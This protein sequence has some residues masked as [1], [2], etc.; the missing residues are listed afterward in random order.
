MIKKL[1]LIFTTVLTINLNSQ[2]VSTF[3]FNVN[4]IAPVGLTTALDAASQRW[5]KYISI[6]I[7]IK[8]NLFFVNSSFL[9]FSAITLSNGRTNFV[10]AP[11]TN[12]IY[13]TALANQLAGLELNPGEYDMDIYVNLATNYYFGTGKPT[14][15]QSDFISTIMHEIGHGLGFYSSG[16]V[17]STNIGSFGNVPAS[18]LAP[19]TTSF[20]W[21]GQDG[22]PSIYDKY[23][24]KQSQ[25]NL[26][27]LAPNNTSTLGDSIKFRTNY[28][29]GPVYANASNGGNPIKLSG[30]TGAFTLGVDL[31]HIH[32]TI[33]G[34]IMSYCWGDGDTV[35]KPAA[36]E[37]GILREIGWNPSTV[38]ITENYTE[39]HFNLYPNPAQ[40]FVDISGENIQSI[41]VYS[42]Q[43]QLLKSEK[44]VNNL[45]YIK[46]SVIELNTGIYFIRINNGNSSYNFSRKLVINKI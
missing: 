11:I 35:R 20:P 2:T 3:S 30:G 28:F 31:L 8:V 9:P 18:A 27:G 29:K 14:T 23:I 41:E 15:T 45:N 42:I 5:T 21:H 17:N 7:P 26:V 12:H 1:L 13:P 16:Y 39:N 25:N 43:G 46:L 36:W 22:F 6:N 44:F 24:I 34:T 33:C 10:G 19:I 38:G 32:P 37:M 40:D 4:G